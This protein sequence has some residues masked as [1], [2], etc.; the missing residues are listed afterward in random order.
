MA[1]TE[2]TAAMLLDDLAALDLPHR[3]EVAKELRKVA[4]NFA[5][6]PDGRN[7]AHTRGC[8][9]TCSIRVDGCGRRDCTAW[10][11]ELRLSGT[12]VANHTPGH[13]LVRLPPRFAYPVC[14]AAAGVGCGAGGRRLR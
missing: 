1:E 12:A 4:E 8:W 11:R 3:R 7:T 14:G 13:H 5:G 9:P 6:V 10:P 2:T